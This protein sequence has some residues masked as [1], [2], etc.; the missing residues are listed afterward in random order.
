MGMTRSE[1][2]ALADKYGLVKRKIDTIPG[3]KKTNVSAPGASAATSQVNT[4]RNRVDGIATRKRTTITAVASTAAAEAALNYTARP[5]RSTV[6]QTVNVQRAKADGGIDYYSGG[7]LVQA[8]ADGGMRYAGSLASGW[9]QIAPT[10]PGG[11]LWA[12]DTRAPWEA[13]ISGDPAKAARSREIAELVVGHLG[14]QVA[15]ARAFADGGLITRNMAAPRPASSQSLAGLGIDGTLTIPGLGDAYVRGI[16][17]DEL[18]KD[19][20]HT[21]HD[22]RRLTGRR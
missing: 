16:V 15:W 10:R 5:R 21:T 19:R 18:G 22:R 3:S 11:I 20:A 17:R 6:I 1:A 13:F 7:S 12:E 8:Y 14:G 9:P 4:F 2:Q